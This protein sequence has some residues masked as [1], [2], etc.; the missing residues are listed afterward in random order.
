MPWPTD[1]PAGAGGLGWLAGRAS[2][3]APRLLG[4][5]LRCGQRSGLIVEVEA[6][7]G[8]DDPASHAYRGP[9]GRNAVMFGPPGRLYVYR[10]YGIHWC[11]NI[12][13]GPAGTGSALLLRAI[14]PVAGL[15]EMWTDRPRAR[16]ET[17]LGSGPGKLCAALGIT[18][19]HDGTDLS[20]EQGPVRLVAPPDTNP[21]RGRPSVVIGPRVGITRAV[22]RPWRFALAGNPHLSRPRLS[23]GR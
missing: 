15:Q 16:I 17:D 5:E 12:V 1:D 18:G 23:V 19:D 21:G 3:I 6:Y 13:C 10:S 2:E 22:E 9:T 14:E 7:E 4:H 20:D 11:A 8:P